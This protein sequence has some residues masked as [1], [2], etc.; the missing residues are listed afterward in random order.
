[1]RM[2]SGFGVGLTVGVGTVIGLYILAPTASVGQ[3]LVTFLF[4]GSI[5]GFSFHLWQMALQGLKPPFFGSRR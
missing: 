1:M 4:Y 3:A 2:M 5:S